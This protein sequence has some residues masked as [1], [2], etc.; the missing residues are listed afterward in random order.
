[1]IFAKNFVFARGVPICV[2]A[3]RRDY[4]NKMPIH[5]ILKM[6]FWRPDIWSHKTNW[7]LHSFRSGLWKWISFEDNTRT[8]IKALKVSWSGWESVDKYLTLRTLGVPEELMVSHNREE[9]MTGHCGH[10]EEDMTGHCGPSP[11]GGMTWYTIHTEHSLMGFGMK[12][13]S[14]ERCE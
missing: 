10:R 14:R 7:L 9:D 6:H 5:L 3:N 13:I 4:P 8:R 11:G 1:M 12:P 2:V